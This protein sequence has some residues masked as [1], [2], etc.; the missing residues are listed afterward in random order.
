MIFVPENVHQ[1][2]CLCKPDLPGK[3][4]LSEVSP[5]EKILMKEKLSALLSGNKQ[6]FEDI[7]IIPNMKM[8]DSILPCIANH[9]VG[10]CI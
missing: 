3:V 1:Q 5:L 4:S 7:L 2:Y 8:Q 10:E 9:R 6:A